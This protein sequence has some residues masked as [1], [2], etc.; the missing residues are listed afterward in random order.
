MARPNRC[1]GSSTHFFGPTGT[2][3]WKGQISAR[4]G[5]PGCSTGQSF[6]TGSS[7]TG[8]SSRSI[9]RRNRKSPR[10]QQHR[11]GGAHGLYLSRFGRGPAVAHRA[12][13]HVSRHIPRRPQLHDPCAHRAQI[14]Y[15]PCP[16][17]RGLPGPHAALG[18]RLGPLFTWLKYKHTPKA[19]I[20][21]RGPNAAESQGRHLPD[22]ISGM[23]PASDGN[24]C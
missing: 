4:P 17:A 21:T 15:H 13:F 6:T 11:M 24:H 2:I 23:K 19:V 7:A 10:T 1:S 8:C 22:S 18:A 9:P 16:A 14:R 12:V 5:S 20:A 3:K